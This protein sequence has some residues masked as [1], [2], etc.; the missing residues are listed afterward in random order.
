MFDPAELIPLA[1]YERAQICPI[2]VEKHGRGDKKLARRLRSVH[3]T[4]GETRELQRYSCTLSGPIQTPGRESER[5]FRA[6]EPTVF[7]RGY[8]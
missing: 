8:Q 1:E 5:I 2:H 7:E 4:L 6:Q 3:V